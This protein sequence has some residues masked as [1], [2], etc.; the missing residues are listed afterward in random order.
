MKREIQFRGKSIETDS[1]WVYGYLNKDD[2]GLFIPQCCGL[3][4]YVIPETVGQYTGL[5]DRNQTRIFEGDVVEVER[6][7]GPPFT[8][9]VK[10]FDNEGGFVVCNKF[11]YVAN[12]NNAVWLTVLG[13]VYD[14]LKFKTQYKGV[15]K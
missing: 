9:V 15:L 12:L 10:Y 2:G 1:Q 11:H 4:P 5:K 7:S 13:N 14:D 3:G 8:G 6:L